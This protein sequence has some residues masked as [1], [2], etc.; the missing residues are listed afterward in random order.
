[1]SRQ[2]DELLGVIRKGDFLVLDTETTGK[3]PESSQAVSV[4]VIQS[5]GRTLLNTLCK[6]VGAIPAEATAIHH[7][8][9]EMVKDVLPFPAELLA[10]IVRDRDVIIYNRSYD[11]GVLNTSTNKANLPR[12]DWWHIA[13]WHC[14]M[15]GFA[16]LFGDWNSY[17]GNYRWQKL[18]TAA[19]FYKIKQEDAHGALVDCQTTLAVCK[20]MIGARSDAPLT[21]ATPQ[22]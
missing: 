2:L 5:D 22:E 17:R 18:S 21:G 8:T 15:E 11:V 19:D 9:D 7:I 3:Y 4:A 20:A 16:E 14:A 10:E 1:M 12:V 13:R 6:P